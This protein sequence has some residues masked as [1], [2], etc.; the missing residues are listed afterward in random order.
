M[1]NIREAYA[2]PSAV[3][4]SAFV[5]E[6]F[7]L[8]MRYSRFPVLCAPFHAYFFEKVAILTFSEFLLV[9]ILD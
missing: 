7:F 2:G 5:T 1:Q 3:W 4:V 8:E 6:V 9:M